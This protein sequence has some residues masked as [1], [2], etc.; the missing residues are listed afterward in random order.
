MPKSIANT[1]G[2]EILP[3]EGKPLPFRVIED[4]R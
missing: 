2:N 3:G 1:L 4:S